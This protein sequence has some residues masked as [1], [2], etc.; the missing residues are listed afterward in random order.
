MYVHRAGSD[1]IVRAPAK[2]NLFFE[3]LRKRGDGFHDIET[4]MVPIGLYDNLIFQ[5]QPDGSIRVACRWA[6]SADSAHYG[7]LPAESDNLVTKALVRL[8]D[9]TGTTQ[10]ASVE[11]IKS[12]PSAAGLGGGSSDAAAAL[13]AANL[14]WNLNLPLDELAQIAGELGSDVPFFLYRSAA[15]CRGRGEQ[16]EPV[17]GLGRLHFVVVRPP[18][19]LSTPEVYRRCRPAESPGRVEPLVAALRRGEMRGLGERLANRL[20]PPAMELSPWI[21]RLK[22]EFA[23]AGCPAHQMSG[24]GSSYFG[25]CRHAGHARAIAGRLRSR[26]LGRVMA[27]SS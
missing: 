25:I 5:P 9:R 22:K 4:L 2:L 17:A 7:A 12:I 3:V 14:G 23:A 13:V 1:V 16:I 21:G 26:G 6:Q 8:R 10:G 24:S 15:I 27:V 11:L 20:E 19:G 18:E